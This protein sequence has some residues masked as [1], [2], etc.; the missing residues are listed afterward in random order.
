MTTY[1]LTDIV[2]PAFSRPHRLIKSGEITELVAKGGRG[3]TKSSYMSIVLVMQLLRHPECHAV[4][5]RKVANTLRNTVYAQMCWAIAAL[6]LTGKCTCTVSPMQII[7]RPTGQRIMFFGADDPGKIKSIKVP[8]GYIGIVWFEE[9]DQFSGP[10]EVRNIE[11][12]TLRGGPYSLTLKSFNPPAASRNWANRYAL[13]TKAGKLVHHSTYLTTP[14]EWLGQRFLDDAEHLRKTNDTKY[15]HEYLGEAVGNGT[16]VFDNLHLRTI[17]D[18]Q[19]KSFDR[20]YNG[21]DWGWYPDPWAFNR[22]HYDAN[23]KVLCIFD[24]A[25]RNK[26]SNADTAEIVK[27]K[28]LPGEIITADNA[29]NKSISDYRALGLRARAAEKGPGSVAYSMKWLQSLRAIIIDPKRCP[30][31][32][33]EFGEYEYSLD[34]Y[35]EPD[36]SYPDA[37]NHHIDAVRYA[38]ERVYRRRGK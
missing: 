23:R 20:I 3:S 17:T 24:E 29:E 21:V 15:R 26:T 5:L 31:T 36:G 27:S 35:G 32:A 8:Q 38:L 18:K 30:Y 10:E 2:S 25:R 11:Q 16:Q 19:I 1:R 12:S 6:G 13:E 14:S 28:T 9:L 4:V 34:K 7:Y 33:R 37:D 22:M